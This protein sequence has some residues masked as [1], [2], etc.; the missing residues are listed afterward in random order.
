MR[1]FKQHAIVFPFAFANGGGY[2]LILIPGTVG[3]CIHIEGN[4][5]RWGWGDEI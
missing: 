2:C 3:V 4:D 5:T 1:D